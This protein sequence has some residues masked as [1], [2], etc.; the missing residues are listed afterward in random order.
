MLAIGFFYQ[1]YV[2]DYS[3]TEVSGSFFY[4]NTWNNCTL[5]IIFNIPSLIIVTLQ[6]LKDLSWQCM[7]EAKGD[8]LIL[9]DLP[10]QNNYFS[11]SSSPGLEVRALQRIR[12]FFNGGWIGICETNLLAIPKTSATKSMTM[13]L[14]LRHSF[15]GGFA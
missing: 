4:H 14:A 1:A 2:L 11:T 8:F 13:S 5:R 6:Q 10:T 9:S 12:I 15:Y 7:L 3:T